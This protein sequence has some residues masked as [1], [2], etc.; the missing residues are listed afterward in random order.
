MASTIDS[1]IFAP[2]TDHLETVEQ[3]T[4]RSRYRV[5]DEWLEFVVTS[6]ARDDDTYH[7]LLADLQQ[8]VDS[9][10]SASE[11]LEAYSAAFAELIETMETATVPGTDTPVDTLGAMYEHY[12]ASSDHFG[13]NFTPGNVGV[14]KAEMAFPD[15]ESIRDATRD[16]PLV[17]GDPACGSGRLAWYAMHRLRE[18]VPETPA[19]VVARDIDETC[20]RMAVLNFALWGMPAWVVHGN[21]LTYET[22]SVWKVDTPPE[23]LLNPQEGLLTQVPPDEAPI[24]TQVN[25]DGAAES[26]QTQTAQPKGDDTTPAQQEED[27]PGNSLEVD[28]NSQV[29]LED[30]G[31]S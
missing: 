6:L 16:E 29:T 20:V 24:R 11:C 8:H 15:A 30:F 9:S 22:W 5:F 21:S 28:S 13:Q 2:L 7:S 3:H 12:G 4:G 14:A 23:M 18:I 10:E 26:A 27:P 19:L 31:Q 1:D 17:V 25:V